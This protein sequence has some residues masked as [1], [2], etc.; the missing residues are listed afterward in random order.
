MGGTASTRKHP[1][2]RSQQPPPGLEEARNLRQKA[3]ACGLSPNH[4]Y[5]VDRAGALEP[6]G[7]KEIVFWKRS[8]ALFR[9]EDG[10]YRAIE[11]CCAHRQLKLSAGSV[12]GCELTCMY[13]GW[14]YGGDGK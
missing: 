1:Y 10:E 11:N 5:I 2:L 7:V 3:R 8:I 13:H 4:W 14:R 12:Q 9:G 6:R